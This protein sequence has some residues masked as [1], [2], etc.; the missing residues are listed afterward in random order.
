M[1]N[2]VIIQTDD[3]G[4]WA[5]P[6]RMPELV[7]PHLAT[8]L[9]ESLE[10]EQFHC[11][12]PV[13]SPAR[14]SLLTGRTPSAHGVHDWLVGGRNPQARPDHYLDGQPTTPEVLARAG[15]QCAMVGKWHVG[16]SRQP[17]PGFEHWWA[18][19]Y[20]G[21]AYKN[22]PIWAADGSEATEPRYLTDAI[23]EEA[24][25]YLAERD[26]ERPFYLQVNYTAPHTPWG[27]DQHL[28]DDLA[29][30]AD[31]TFDSVP[32]ED[33]H[34]WAKN[35]DDFDADFADPLPALRGYCA[36]LTAVDRGLGRIRAALAEQ[37]VA[38]ETVVVYL[39]DN[40]FACGHGGIWGKGNG[41]WPLNFFD[42]SVRVPCV[43]HVPGGR[44]GRSAAL[45]S[46]TGLHPTLCE[47]A[48]VTPDEDRWAAAESFAD[49]LLGERESGE[50]V[51]VVHS[52]Y[53]GGRMITDGRW[54][55]VARADG[56][57]ELYD[58]EHDPGERV[59]LAG[60]PASAPVE[61]RWRVRL[62]EWFAEHER[63]GASGWDRPVS[64]YG[65]VHPV[66]RGRSGLDS[67]VQPS[68]RLVGRTPGA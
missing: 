50:E 18:H 1:R 25:G 63:A 13:C 21:G 37:G 20:G 45:L 10:L 55:Y 3:Q 53:G 31:C 2:F 4:P 33:R 46:A 51:V 5:M 68:E 11:A 23:T 66:W 28:A 8:L 49:V 48:G 15:Y 40:G 26:R 17:A 44:T 60:V 35:R 9:E 67:Y 24:L 43:A 34:E 64:G 32:R 62:E 14:A 57:A 41:T 54:K 12:S 56:S 61:E 36:S 30:Y 7:M 27:A 59:N 39:S 6:H 47:L 19:R 52:E 22:A 29:L 42:S 16:D 65:Q 38:G 58:R